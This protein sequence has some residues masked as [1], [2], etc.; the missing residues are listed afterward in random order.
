MH[1]VY[2]QLELNVED[3][4]ERQYPLLMSNYAIEYAVYESSLFKRLKREPVQVNM[5]YTPEMSELD[6]SY[7][8]ASKEEFWLKAKMP[9]TPK[10]HQPMGLL[11]GGASMALAETVGSAGSMMYID[12]NKQA[13]VGLQINGNHLKSIKE[14]WIF[15]I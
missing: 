10:V 14:G 3:F 9:V 15:A 1:D 4:G 11:H 12:P 8:S 7:T 6:I 13:V 5:P 2:Y